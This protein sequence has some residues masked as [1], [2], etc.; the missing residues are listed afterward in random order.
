MELDTLIDQHFTGQLEQK[1]EKTQMKRVDSET[2]AKL[3]EKDVKVESVLSEE[4]QTKVKETFEKSIDNK[5]MMVTV[6]AMSPDAAPVS[7][8]MPEFMRRMKEMSMNGGGMAMMGAMPDNYNVTVNSN[9]K[10]TSKILKARGENKEKLAKQAYDLAM[11][12]QGL[13]KGEDLS[14]FINRSVDLLAD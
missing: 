1:L 4:D 12:S 10:A 3:I 14:N 7:V 11:L 6:E 9:H 2:T 8:T 5:S 13:L